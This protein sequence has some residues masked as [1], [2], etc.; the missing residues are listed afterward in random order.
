MKDLQRQL[1]ET[2]HLVKTLSTQLNDLREKVRKNYFFICIQ[3][4]SLLRSLTPYTPALKTTSMMMLYYLCLG[5]IIECENLYRRK[6]SDRPCC[7]AARPAQTL[8]RTCASW[9]IMWLAQSATRYLCCSFA[10]KSSQEK[11]LVRPSFRSAGCNHD[12]QHT[13]GG[14]GN[15]CTV[16]VCSRGMCIEPMGCE[17]S[18]DTNH[19]HALNYACE[20]SWGRNW[21]TLALGPSKSSTSQFW[22][23]ALAKSFLAFWDGFLWANLKNIL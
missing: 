13:E 20:L 22:S 2:T 23:W 14:Y 10:H 8:A 16:F 19:W 15:S 12:H 5:S 4:V 18:Y 1:R 9:Q 21:L 3:G 11:T 7:S 17:L 6:I